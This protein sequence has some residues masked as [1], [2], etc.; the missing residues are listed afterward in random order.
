MTFRGWI[1]SWKKQTRTKRDEHRPN[2]GVL[3]FPRFGVSLRIA[4]QAADHEVDHD[5]VEHHHFEARDGQ[6]RRPER[7]VADLEPHMDQ[8]EE[9]KEC[10]RRKDFLGVPAPGPAPGVIGPS[11]VGWIRLNLGHPTACVDA[12]RGQPYPYTIEPCP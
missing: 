1:P 2:F 5:P 4:V 8:H 11:Q 7:L 3:V 9:D 6:D 10:V 12:F